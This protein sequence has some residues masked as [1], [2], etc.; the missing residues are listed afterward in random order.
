[1]HMKR[2]VG[3]DLL[4]T[5]ILY[6]RSSQADEIV[7]ACLI[8]SSN[9]EG[10]P[11]AL[12]YV[13][14]LGKNGRVG[15]ESSIQRMPKKMQHAFLQYKAE[16]AKVSNMRK[17]VFLLWYLGKEESTDKIIH[18]EIFLV[19]PFYFWGFLNFFHVLFWEADAVILY[20]IS[21][22]IF[23]AEICMCVRLTWSIRIF[24]NQ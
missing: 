3:S 1:M 20:I 10:Q 6:L 7:F 24:S 15:K 18:L 11:P 9:Y 23:T 4:I 13:T 21:P 22:R 19:L 12:W 2:Y 17:V 8:H 14:E 16:I 5:W